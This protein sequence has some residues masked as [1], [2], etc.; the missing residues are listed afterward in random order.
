MGSVA[1]G[2]ASKQLEIDIL[3]GKPRPPDREQQRLAAEVGL[4]GFWA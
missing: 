1:F 2:T 4:V 3:D